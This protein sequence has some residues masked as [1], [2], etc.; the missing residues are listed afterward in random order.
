M[1]MK[2]SID[3]YENLCRLDVFG[4]IDIA[5]GD[6]KVHQDGWYEMLLQ[7]Y[8]TAK[9]QIGQ[10]EKVKEFVAKLTKKSRTIREL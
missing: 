2:T 7:C 1:C 4:V 5:R 6:I 8:F 9:Q 10:F 3:D